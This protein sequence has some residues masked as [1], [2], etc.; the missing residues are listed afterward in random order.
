MPEKNTPE[1]APK[2]GKQ[3]AR[4][5][6]VGAGLCLALMAA[7]A[8]FAWRAGLFQNME[9]L[10]SAVERAGMWGPLL[11]ISIQILQIVLPLIPGGAVLAGGVVCFGPWRGLLLNLLGTY[12]GSSIN[13]ALARR[14]G[15]PLAHQLVSESAREKYFRWLEDQKRFDKLF[16]L[17]ILLPFFPDD[18]LCLVAGLSKMTFRRFLLI[19]LLKLPSVAVYSALYL[20]ARL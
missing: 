7:G 10:Q 12:A 8:F 5:M 20:T 9:I 19:L 16:A 14:W 17:A 6:N 1:P 18:T 15:R 4:W 3:L 2:P 13:F 11:F